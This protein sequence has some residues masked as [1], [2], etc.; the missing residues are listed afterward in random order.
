MSP[1]RR[2]EAVIAALEAQRAVLGDS[3]V[4]LAIGPLRSQLANL[5]WSVTESV[6]QALRQVTVLFLDV[7]GSTRLSQQL[8]PEEILDVIDGALER[9][10]DIVLSHGGT[11]LKYVGDGMLAVFGSR[12]VH[13]D[14]PERAV[15]CGLALV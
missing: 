2:V 4:D 15:R 6:E 13:E 10:T 12:E 8:D 11:V 14:D 3:T 5:R 1:D 9:F 7:A